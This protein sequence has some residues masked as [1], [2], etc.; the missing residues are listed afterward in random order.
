MN[1]Y[2]FCLY[3]WRNSRDVICGCRK[4]TVVLDLE[5]FVLTTMLLL[6]KNFFYS[7][8]D[9]TNTSG[10]NMKCKLPHITAFSISLY[11]GRFLIIRCDLDLIVTVVRIKVG[12]MN[13]CE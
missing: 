13:N 5:A 3:N 7:H 4:S 10:M 12:I 1:C 11:V 2:C 9:T 6:T 8:K